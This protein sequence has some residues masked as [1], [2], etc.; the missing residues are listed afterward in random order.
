MFNIKVNSPSCVIV[1]ANLLEM[2]LFPDP[3]TLTKAR[4]GGKPTI[5]RRFSNKTLKGVKET[6]TEK[7]EKILKDQVSPSV[8]KWSMNAAARSCPCKWISPSLWI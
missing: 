3:P 5:A 7:K 1:P 4:L 6:K 2:T 8:D